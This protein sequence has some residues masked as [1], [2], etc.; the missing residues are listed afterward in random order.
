[1]AILPAH[2]PWYEEIFA[3]PDLLS[4][5]VM[6]FGYQEVRV[7]SWYLRGARPDGLVQRA[8]RRGL[9]LRARLARLAG[10]RPP[11]ADFPPEYGHSSLASLLG[12][13]G[14]REVRSLD[15][16]DQ[17][18][19]ARYDMNHPIPA[20]EFGRYGA[21]IDIGS[22][23]HVF[24]TRQCLENC[25]RM[26]RVGGHYFVHTCVNGYFAHGLHVFNPEALLQAFV[27]NGFDIVYR[28]YTTADGAP[29]TDPRRGKD[30][31]LWVVG[32]KV[33]DIPVFQ[34]PQ[35]GWWEEYYGEEDAEARKKV[36]RDGWARVG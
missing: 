8:R 4:D 1:M 12:S 22:L 27:L 33:K 35:Q 19:E 5:P 9:A 21:F 34:M 2:V 20:E 14:V 18:A 30:V 31:L 3:I 13:R 28:R 7:P 11:L 17:R 25:M 36:Q 26:V 32:R 10:T 29:L 23:E 6:I 24:D 15:L 16:F